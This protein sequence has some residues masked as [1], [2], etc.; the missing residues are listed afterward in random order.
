MAMSETLVRVVDTQTHETLCNLEAP[1]GLSINSLSFDQDGRHLLGATERRPVIVWNLPLI[2]NSLAGLGL[3][4]GG[5]GMERGLPAVALATNV[6]TALGSLI[7]RDRLRALM[8]ERSLEDSASTS[9]LETQI[10]LWNNKGFIHLQKLN[11]IPEAIAAY[12]SAIEL[13]P[14]DAWACRDLGLIY[15]FGPPEL[16]NSEKA[17]DLLLVAAEMEPHNLDNVSRLGMAVYRFGAYELALSLLT[18]SESHGKSGGLN[19]FHQALCYRQ[20]KDREK[21]EE[22]FQRARRMSQDTPRYELYRLAVLG[23]EDEYRK[24]K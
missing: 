9:S 19:L 2:R 11:E 6:I 20:L 15:L 13:D 8:I 12:E 22:C 14:T 21:A 3:D 10:G 7:D 23:C 18:E 4:W 16:R 17:L 5:P 24:L 1:Y